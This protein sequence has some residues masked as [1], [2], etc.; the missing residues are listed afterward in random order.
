MF[1][2][3]KKSDIGVSILVRRR[4]EMILSTDVCQMDAI[5]NFPRQKENKIIKTT[6]YKKGQ[7]KRDTQKPSI[8]L[9]KPPSLW[10]KNGRFRTRRKTRIK[11]F[12]PSGFSYFPQRFYF[13]FL[14][15]FSLPILSFA[16]SS[17]CSF[18][19][20]FHY[21]R[22]MRRLHTK[23]PAERNSINRYPSFK[24]RKK[25][26]KRMKKEQEKNW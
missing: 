26:E 9:V 13:R 11:S 23:N 15:A 21:W 1:V 24:K 10:P 4:I 17:F 3:K 14:F 16:C 8:V 20:S 5:T 7:Y 19:S 25:K 6:L 12:R 18:L 2:F 22:L